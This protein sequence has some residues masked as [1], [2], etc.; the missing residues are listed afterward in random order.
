MKIMRLFAQIY[1][2]WCLFWLGYDIYFAYLNYNTPSFSAFLIFGLIQL[3]GLC[4]SISWLRNN[5]E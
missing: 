1:F 3:A 2:T 5:Y 4:I